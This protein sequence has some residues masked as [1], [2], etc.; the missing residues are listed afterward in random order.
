VEDTL[1]EGAVAAPG[2]DAVHLV[3]APRRPRMHWRIDVV[4]R[5]FIGRQLSVRVHVPGARQQHELVFRECRID[6]RERDAVKCQIPGG[7]PG[8]FPFVR[9]RDDVGIGQVWPI[10][11]ANQATRRWWLRL[12]RIAVEPASDIEMIELL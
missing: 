3:D 4:E 1:E 5:P 6:Q 11:V 10:E 12:G 8:I 9:H 7:I 2:G